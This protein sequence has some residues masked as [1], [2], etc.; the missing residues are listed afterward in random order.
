MSWDLY[1]LKS[2]IDKVYIFTLQV[3]FLIFILTIANFSLLCC[4]RLMFPVGKKSTATA[5]YRHL[6]LSSPQTNDLFERLQCII[7]QKWVHHSSP[8][9][10][11]FEKHC[12]WWSIIFNT[13]V[14]VFLVDF[15]MQICIQP[16]KVYLFPC[17]LTVVVCALCLHCQVSNLGASIAKFL[18]SFRHLPQ[19]L[20]VFLV[21]CMSQCITC[22]SSNV[23]SA[24]LFIPIV[25][26]L[27]TLF[28]FCVVVFAFDWIP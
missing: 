21:I 6:L 15:V 7:L 23:A 1:W 27:V 20:I 10:C 9:F 25:A 11:S 12:C 5:K 24:T 17:V 16:N 18:S 3:I 28:L 2:S 19:S 13:M 8:Q 14:I 26:E 22:F 4:F